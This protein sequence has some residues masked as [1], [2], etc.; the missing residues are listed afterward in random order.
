MGPPYTGLYEEDQPRYTDFKNQY[1][2]A[3][4]LHTTLYKVIPYRLPFLFFWLQ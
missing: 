1:T 2:A 4:P 3:G